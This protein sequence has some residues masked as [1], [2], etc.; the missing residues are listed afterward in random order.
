MEKIQATAYIV[1]NY[2]KYVNGSISADVFIFIYDSNKNVSLIP[3]EI[4][5]K[6]SSIEHSYAFI[7]NMNNFVDLF[8]QSEV[9]QNYTKKKISPRY[10]RW[11]KANTFVQLNKLSLRYVKGTIS[12]SPNS[13]NKI[14]SEKLRIINNLGCTITFANP[15]KKTNSIHQLANINFYIHKHRCQPLYDNLK[16]CTI[17]EETGVIVQKTYTDNKWV[18]NSYEFTNNRIFNKKMNKI[19]NN[20]CNLLICSTEDNNNLFDDIIKIIQ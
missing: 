5:H 10:D 9:W 20:Y 8:Y 18:D 13:N 19:L 15:F 3:K 17:T 14:N 6:N 16:H 2:I 1:E 7:K 11:Y 4:L 12:C